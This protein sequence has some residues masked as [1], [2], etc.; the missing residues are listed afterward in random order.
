M[1]KELV[2]GCPTC[3]KK[4]VYKTSES[5]PFCSHRCK[6]IDLG[7]WFDESYSIEGRDNTV[8]IEDPNILGNDLDENH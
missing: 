5:R 3:K 4:F 2:V 8:Y 1:T 6:M 7:H